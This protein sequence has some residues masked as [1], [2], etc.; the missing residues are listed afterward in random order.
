MTKDR[1]F[2]AGRRKVYLILELLLLCLLPVAGKGIQ[3]EIIK[4]KCK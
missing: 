3:C 1:E 4:E 2:L